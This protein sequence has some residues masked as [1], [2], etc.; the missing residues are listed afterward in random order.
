MERK[1]ENMERK[2]LYF[3]GKL[4]LQNN[5]YYIFW[6]RLLVHLLSISTGNI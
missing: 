3:D 1:V 6:L 4:N 5:G 2:L